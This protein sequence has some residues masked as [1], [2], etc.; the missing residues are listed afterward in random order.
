M[1]VVEENLKKRIIV[2][3]DKVGICF[4][5]IVSI[6]FIFVVIYIL[7]CSLEIYWI[8]LGCKIM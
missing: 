3:D 4:F 6:V 1:K 5:N 7:M 8:Y 2:W